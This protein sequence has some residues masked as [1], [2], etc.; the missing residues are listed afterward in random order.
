[1]GAQ[2]ASGCS[3][4][5]D[6][7]T[8]AQKHDVP[9]ITPSGPPRLELKLAELDAGE[10]DFSVPS[11]CK[12]AVRNTGGQPLTLTFVAKSCFC[13]DAIVPPEPV[14]PGGEGVVVVRWTPIPGKTGPER[15]TAE[16]ASNDPDQPT[17]KLAVTGLVN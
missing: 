4:T 3:K 16:I 7:V 14:L 6:P 5:D 15:I 12:F 11:D 1:L 2:L 17:I 10:L 8:T 13:T 9:L